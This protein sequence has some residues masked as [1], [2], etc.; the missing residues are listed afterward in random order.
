MRISWVIESVEKK[1]ADKSEKHN[2]ADSNL[3]TN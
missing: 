1:Y 2:R 3:V